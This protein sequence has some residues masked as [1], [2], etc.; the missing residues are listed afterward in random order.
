A[1]FPALNTSQEFTALMAKYMKNVQLS[2]QRI[3]VSPSARQ[4][5]ILDRGGLLIPAHVFT[6]HKGLYGNMADRMSEVLDLNGIAGIE[7]WLSADSSMA[8]QISELDAYSFLTNSDAHSLGKIGREYNR[9][10]M[11]KPSFAEF[12]QALGT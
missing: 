7:L 4:Q 1:Y 5:E 3:Y 11:V 12:R 8:G 2:S 9:I 6:P 10:D